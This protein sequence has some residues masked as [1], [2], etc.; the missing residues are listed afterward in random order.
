MTFT[1]PDY[2]Y[3]LPSGIYLTQNN[4]PAIDSLAANGDGTLTVTGK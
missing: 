3:V 2:M 1:T 4:Q